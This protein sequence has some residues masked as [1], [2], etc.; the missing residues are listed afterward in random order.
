MSPVTTKL[1]IAGTV[2]NLRIS[3]ADMMALE[4]KGAV[5]NIAT[6]FETLAQCLK[7]ES[8]DRVPFSA[9]ELADMVSVSDMPVINAAVR[10]ALG[11]ETP[12]DQTAEVAPAV[13]A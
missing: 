6:T 4:T 8:G 12:A 13:Q 1:T 2:Y 3:M 7:T 5:G 9:I 11:K 10:T